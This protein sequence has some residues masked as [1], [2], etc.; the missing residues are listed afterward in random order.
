MCVYMF[1][2]VCLCVCFHICESVHVL[3]M[4]D[5]SYLQTQIH[6]GFLHFYYSNIIFLK[7]F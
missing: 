1:S 3:R 2:G 4:N 7:Y 6:A 5:K